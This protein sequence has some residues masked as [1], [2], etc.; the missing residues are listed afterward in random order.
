MDE[1]EEREPRRRVTLPS[2]IVPRHCDV[3]RPSRKKPYTIILLFSPREYAHF[4][5][6]FF[7]IFPFGSACPPPP[8]DRN[9]SAANVTD[10]DD[11]VCLRARVIRRHNISATGTRDRNRARFN[12][13]NTVPRV[14]RFG[15]TFLTYRRQMLS[16]LRRWKLES[17]R[18]TQVHHS[19]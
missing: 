17:I 4:F 7:F 15:S 9:P 5:G 1:K 6:F 12:D 10:I 16:P 8:P 14:F 18:R 11:S 13:G 3:A 19:I 2:T